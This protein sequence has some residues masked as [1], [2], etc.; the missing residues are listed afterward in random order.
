MNSSREAR[1]VA[2]P[3]PPCAPADRFL[4]VELSRGGAII[5]RDLQLVYFSALC[6]SVR[7]H[8]CPT[9]LGDLRTVSGATFYTDADVVSAERIILRA[10][11]DGAGRGGA[12]LSPGAA[13]DASS[14]TAEAPSPSIGS[15]ADAAPA[16]PT[17]AA[18]ASSTPPAALATTSARERPLNED[19]STAVSTQP[20]SFA[21]ALVSILPPAWAR[22]VEHLVE[23]AMLTCHI[24]SEPPPASPI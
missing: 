6:A 10:F 13:R 2:L 8:G 15:V 22:R 23:E 20:S 17:E 1:L 19:I 18:P 5:A 24:V 3:A 4:L 7:V 11:E 12:P 16:S 21:A 9:A 14:A